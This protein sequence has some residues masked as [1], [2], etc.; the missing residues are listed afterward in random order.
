MRSM[1]LFR[2][3]LPAVAALSG[4]LA[5]AAVAAHS[6]EPPAAVA[7]A[8]TGAACV[9]R[10]LLPHLVVFAQP[11]ESRRIPLKTTCLL[12]GP[13][14]LGVFTAGRRVAVLVWPGNR[15]HV[16]ANGALATMTLSQDRTPP[17]GY[18]VPAQSVTPADA[19]RSAVRTTPGE[20]TVKDATRATLTIRRL[21]GHLVA[22]GVTEV[23]DGTWD[24]QELTA[25]LEVRRHGWWILYRR[26]D[27]DAK[28]AQ[29]FYGDYQ[30]RL[31]PASR[32]YRVAIPATPTWAPSTT[33]PHCS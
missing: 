18:T 28:A 19:A 21:H 12:V 24:K 23:F 20:F 11:T 8:V 10:S 14:K 29:G 6:V 33:R 25:R 30:V 26:F 9:V 27:S 13:V 16:V 1:R 4:L 7:G 17:G 3:T 15:H 5:Q 2:F 32:A 31:P 22:Y